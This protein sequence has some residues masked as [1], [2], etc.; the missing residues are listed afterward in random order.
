MSVKLHVADVKRL[1]H[2]RVQWDFV[3]NINNLNPTKIHCMCTFHLLIHIV[4]AMHARLLI[5]SSDHKRVLHCSP[6]I[7]NRLAYHYNNSV[8]QSLF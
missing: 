1:D 2:A 8:V 5:P 3:Q 4:V 7:L 6:E